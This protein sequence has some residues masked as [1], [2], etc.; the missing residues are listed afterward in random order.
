MKESKRTL[1]GSVKRD[2]FKRHHKDL[3]PSLYACDLD[4]VLL[5]KEPVPDIVAALDYK[6]D[7]DEIQFS[8][9]IA[10]NALTRR[11]I[12]VFIV[13]GD[14]E[15][16]TFC[17]SRYEGGHHREPRYKTTIVKTTSNWNEFEA[18]EFS[19]RSEFAERYGDY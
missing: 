9:V 7:N 16:G 12:Q 18:W 3:S 6:A 5:A 17:I 10:Y 19:I 4:F 14:S 2:E 13:Q 8:E 1:Q 11:G 15:T